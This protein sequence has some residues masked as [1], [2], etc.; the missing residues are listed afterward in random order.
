MEKLS[1]NESKIDTLAAEKRDSEIFFF[2]WF[3]KFLIL[4]HVRY[5]YRI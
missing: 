2:N 3:L 4:C 5:V 1:E